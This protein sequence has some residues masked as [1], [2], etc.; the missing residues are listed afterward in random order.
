[1]RASPLQAQQGELLATGKG[2][3][4][5]EESEESRSKALA[6]RT[7]TTYE[8]DAADK[9]AMIL[10]VLNLYGSRGS[11]CG[12]HK[13]ESGCA[14]PGEVWQ[15]AARL[16]SSRDEGKNCQKSAAVIVG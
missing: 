4:R 6:R 1:M 8:A 16:L 14:V 3:L 13:R 2:V 12:G 11:R 5:E 15:F 7:E 10:E 9:R